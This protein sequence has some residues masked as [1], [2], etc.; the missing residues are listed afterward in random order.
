MANHN[1][2]MF[3]DQK[4]IDLTSLLILLFFFFF[5]VGRPLQK[6]RASAVLNRI[7]MKFGRIRPQLN[8]HQLTERGLR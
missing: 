4:L 8:P 1:G 7:E 6:A 2:I 3:F 5:L